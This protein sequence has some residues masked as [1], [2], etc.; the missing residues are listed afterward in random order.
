MFEVV[1]FLFEDSRMRTHSS[2]I[3]YL[4]LYTN[5]SVRTRLTKQRMKMAPILIFRGP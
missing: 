4:Q 2:T 5:G 3:R 1:I